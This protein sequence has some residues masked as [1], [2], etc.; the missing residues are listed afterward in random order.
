MKVEMNPLHK[1]MLD[2]VFD[3]FS[4]LSNGGFVSLMH[5]TAGVTRYSPLAV[6]LMKLPGEYIPNGAIDFADYLHPEDKKRYMDVMGP[7]LTGESQT[8]DI[9]YRIRINTG[10]YS[11]FRAVGAVLRGDDG[12]PSL[13]GGVTYNEGATETTDSVTVLPNKVAYIRDL[14]RLIKEEKNTISLEVGISGFTDINIRHGYSYGNRILQEIAWLLQETVEGRATVYRLEEATFGILFT[15]TPKEMVSTI[16]D[17]IR[18]MLQQGIEI[19]GNQNILTANGGLISTFKTEADADSVY[20]CLNYAYEESAVSRHGELVDF[21]GS[22]DRGSVETLELINAIRK[23][24]LDECKGF[25]ITYTPVIAVGT[26]WMNGAEASV[27][28]E[29][30]EYGRV[31]AYRFL[32]VLE[33]DFLFEELGDFI[34]KSALSEGKKFLEQDPDFLLCV[35]VYRLQ[36]D[37]G[38]FVD[39]LFELLDEYDFPGEKLSL[40]VMGDYRSIDTAVMK[41][42]IEKLHKR[43][44]LVIIDNFGSGKD[45]IGFLKEMP[46]D[47]VNMDIRFT[48]GI[49]DDERDRK[50]L[51]HLTELAHDCVEHINVKGITGKEVYDIVRTMPVTTVQGSYFSGVLGAEDILSGVNRDYFQKKMNA[52][53]LY[54]Q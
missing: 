8:Y 25:S 22:Y 4:M 36:L 28:W 35:D 47:A 14:D 24:I 32:P 9:T 37:T 48:D 11:N 46:V 16:Y 23:D 18:I 54:S 12:K 42:I 39:E 49:D 15:D 20:T 6:E 52:R 40:N 10:E 2:D 3:A 38:Y 43:G 31:E 19:A 26:G 5:V 34:L 30:E 27:H 50:I 17:H 41:D 21:N 13:I 44:V 33:R 1:Q 51:S 7:L 53:E 45:S 29:S